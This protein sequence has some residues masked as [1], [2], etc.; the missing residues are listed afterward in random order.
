[1]KCVVGLIPNDEHV[2]TAMQELRAAGFAEDKMCVLVKTNEVWKRLGGKK[3]AQIVYRDTIIGALLG[4]TLGSTFGVV[5]GVLN[6]KLM[7]CPIEKSLIFLMLIVLFCTI[8]GGLFG[9]IVGL[10]QLERVI[11]SYIDGVRHGQALFVVETSKERTS[12]A[13]RILDKAHGTAVQ[14]IHEEAE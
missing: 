9:A 10:D 2:T 13:R 1:M 6:C 11:D 4:F 8:S 12:D 14:V 7:D 3:K 5:A